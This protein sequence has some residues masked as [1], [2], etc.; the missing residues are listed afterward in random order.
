MYWERLS[1]PGLPRYSD[2]RF[3]D[4]LGHDAAPSFLFTLKGGNICYEYR[5]DD[6]RIVPNSDYDISA[7]VR[8]ENVSLARAF[9]G[10][11]L[12]D[13]LG[14]RIPGSERISPL[15]PHRPAGGPRPARRTTADSV[16][17]TPDAGPADENGWIPLLVEIPSD[18]P[19]A[20]AVRLQLWVVQPQVWQPRPDAAVDAIFRQDVRAKVW[21]D[22]IELRRR[23][24]VRLGFS[25]DGH[26]ADQ[27]DPASLTIAV[28]EN[29]GPAA[30]AEISVTAE[31]GDMAYSTAL[32]LPAAENSTLD[33]PLP[34]LPPGLYHATLQLRVNGRSLQQR[35]TQ[36]AI[37]PRL[38]ISPT[39]TPAL[40]I[41]LGLAD[42][43]D[44]AGAAALTA[45]VGCGSA[46]VMTLAPTGEPT[47]AVAATLTRSRELLRALALRRIESVGVV[48]IPD[49]GDPAHT[50]TRDYLADVNVAG[51]RFGRLLAYFGGAVQIWQFG[52]EPVELTAGAAWE[53]DTVIRVR[54]EM[55]RF[56]HFP[57]LVVPRSVF[58]AEHHAAPLRSLFDQADAN[59]SGGMSEALPNGVHRSVWVPPGIP[60]RNLAWHLAFLQSDAD[61]RAGSALGDE[62]PVDSAGDRWLRIDPDVGDALSREARQID[63]AQRIAVAACFSPARLYLPAPFRCDDSGGHPAW[64]PNDEF[65]VVRTLYHYLGGKRVLRALRLGPHSVGVVF[66]GPSGNCLIAWTWESDRP[67]ECE[68]LVG[69]DAAAVDARGNPR[70]LDGED[71]AVRVRLTPLPLIITNVN[72]PLMLMRTQCQLTP[73]YIEMQ[74]P[75]AEPVLLLKNTFDSPIS[76]RLD[77]TPPRDWTLPQ[78]GYEF[79]L[80]PGE[81]FERQL[82]LLLPSRKLA[83]QEFV[84]VRVDVRSPDAAILKL[85]FPLTLGLRD[86]QLDALAQWD[87]DTLVVRQS[88]RNLSPA[89]V[90]FTSYCQAPGRARAEGAFLNVP[91]GELREQIYQFNHARELAG[92]TL[93]LGIQ[94]IRGLRVLDQLVDVP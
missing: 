24:R 17:F 10:C 37:L 23:P 79:Q 46:K 5:G 72:L 47:P 85:R 57:E 3:D 77:I 11:F 1:G 59:E 4:S 74:V 82:Q 8:F 41:D 73:Q 43:P 67:A 32:T 83:T 69:P 66:A 51:E 86:V 25:H 88:L 68:I 28:Q 65:F 90:S 93:A 40:G 9:I 31:N 6:L 38:E 2:G 92:A 71:G 7:Y 18:F 12:V 48:A 52:S 44:V 91:P 49:E 19:H 64:V 42:A 33:A 70:E 34:D 81:T 63:F 13:D 56:I 35:S 62:L 29:L 54:R 75:T 45:A 55:E 53:A 14:Q 36:F 50:P 84:D 78:A 20:A 30:T 15:E 58:D 76:G 80:R 22:D 60:A 27:E 39:R 89:S 87:G 61:A 26:I 21:F 94:E 16:F